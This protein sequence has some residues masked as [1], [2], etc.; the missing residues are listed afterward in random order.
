MPLM[1]N[2]FGHGILHS[3]LVC[4]DAGA[5]VQIELNSRFKANQTSSNIN[6]NIK[7]NILLVQ[8][9]GLLHDIKRKEK[10]HGEKGAKFTE[11]FLKKRNYSL[12][13]EEIFIICTAI[14]KHEAFNINNEKGIVLLSLIHFM[15]QINSGGGKITLLIHYGIC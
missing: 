2:N 6:K 4:R 7:R 8:I 11:I 3:S 15:M 9:A 10:Y 1:E 14:K 12:S 13:L 5:I